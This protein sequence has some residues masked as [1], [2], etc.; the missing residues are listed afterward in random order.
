[1][2]VPKNALW[3]VRGKMKIVTTSAIAVYIATGMSSPLRRVNWVK[4]KR[5]PMVFGGVR[6]KRRIGVTV[7]YTEYVNRYGPKD[8]HNNKRFIVGT[9]TCEDKCADHEEDTE[10]D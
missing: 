3:A 5:G 10:D 6:R 4:G 2:T 1:V 8:A 7:T 9:D